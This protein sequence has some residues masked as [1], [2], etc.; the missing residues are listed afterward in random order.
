VLR[1]TLTGLSFARNGAGGYWLA[2]SDGGV[3]ALGDT[4]FDG[5]AAGLRLAARI[6][7]I[8]SVGQGPA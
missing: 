6:V 2:A 1:I 5:S 7:G 8:A 3:F 4:A